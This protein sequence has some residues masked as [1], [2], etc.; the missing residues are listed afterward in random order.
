MF[1]ARRTLKWNWPVLLVAML[2]CQ[3]ARADGRSL[4]S[5]VPM[6]ALSSSPGPQDESNLQVSSTGHHVAVKLEERV[7]DAY[8]GLAGLPLR[9][10]VSR[11]S[12]DSN[13]RILQEIVET[14]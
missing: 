2:L 1:V 5:Q 13:S 10:Y 3:V 14:L 9:E 8:T 11:L 4:A 12:T 6:L 7:I